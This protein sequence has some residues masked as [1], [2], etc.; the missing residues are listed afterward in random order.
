LTDAHANRSEEEQVA[1][2]ELLNHVETRE[3]GHDVDRVGDDR[4]DE[5]VLE[6]SADKV[7][8]SVVDYLLLVAVR[9]VL[10]NQLTDEVNTGQL[11]KRLEQASSY[12]PLA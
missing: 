1:T 6:A 5:R 3:C 9:R 12:E 11:L 2:S 4:G 8:S 7:L 10:E